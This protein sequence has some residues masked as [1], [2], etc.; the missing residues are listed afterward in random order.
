MASLP[1]QWQIQALVKLGNF[2]VIRKVLIRAIQKCTFYWIQATVSKVMGI[3]VKFWLVLPC[4][5]TKYGQVMWL[6]VQILKKLNF[7]LILHLI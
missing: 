2:F 7:S 5:L 6:M 3:Y 1:K 4:P